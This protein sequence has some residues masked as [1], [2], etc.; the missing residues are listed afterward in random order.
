MNIFF[1]S[2]DTAGGLPQTKSAPARSTPD[3]ASIADLCY[4]IRRAAHLS[5]SGTTVSVVQVAVD[6]AQRVR[7]R[8]AGRALGRA[9]AVIE[10]NRSGVPLPQRVAANAGQRCQARARAGH[11]QRLRETPAACRNNRRPVRRTVTAWPASRASFEQPAAHA[12][13]RRQPDVQLERVI[14]GKARERI[15]ARQAVAPPAASM[16]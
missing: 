10:V 15:A 2:I 8:P 7:A 4:R 11:Q 14:V 3:A 16:Y 6:L 9:R 1:F 13:L 12:A 5:S